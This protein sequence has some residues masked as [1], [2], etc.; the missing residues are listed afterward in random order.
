MWPRSAPS[1]R[2]SARSPPTRRSRGWSRPWPAD[3]DA[4]VAAIRAA[5][6]SARAAVWARRR[7]LAGRPGRRRGRAGDHRHRRHAGR[8]RTRTRRAPSRPTSA[9]SGSRPMCAF[10]DHG[11]HGTGETLVARRCARARPRRGTVA[12]HI[13]VLDARAGP[14]S[15]TPSAAR[16]WSA[17]TP[18]AARRRSCDHITDVGLEYSIGFAAPRDV[19][20]AIEAIPEQAWRAAVDGDGEPRDGAQVAELTAWMPP[21][22]RT[23]HRPRTGRPGCGSSPAANAPTPAPSCG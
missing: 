13:A 16:C 9:A 3:V 2:C 12:D 22:T 19:K 15:R 5:R 17:P 21:T 1:R 10:V 11:E 20:A 14:A 7:P 4:A 8:P 18:A 23:G 6:A